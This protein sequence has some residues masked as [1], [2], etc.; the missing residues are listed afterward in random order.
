VPLRANLGVCVPR[1]RW[2]CLVNCA[3]R[4]S[5]GATSETLH[6]QTPLAIESVKQEVFIEPEEKTPILERLA[7]NGGGPIRNRG[8]QRGRRVAL[9]EDR[10]RRLKDRVRSC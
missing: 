9:Q 8:A 3:N 7:E 5:P 6:P 1:S 10:R 2:Q 4:E